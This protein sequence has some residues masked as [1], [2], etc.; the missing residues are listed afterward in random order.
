[1]SMY[2]N[3]PMRTVNLHCRRCD[4]P[5]PLEVSFGWFIE[6]AKNGSTGHT[7]RAEICEERPGL[8]DRHI[9]DVWCIKCG[10]CG[11]LEFVEDNKKGSIAESVGRIGDLR[12]NLRVNRWE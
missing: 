12:G 4:C 3:G 6:I 1:M 2:K 5:L 10:C 9:S 11:G 8:T 7:V